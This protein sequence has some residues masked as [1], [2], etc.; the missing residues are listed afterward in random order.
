M[1]SIRPIETASF[2]ALDRT[3]SAEMAGDFAKAMESSGVFDYVLVPDQLVSWWPKGLWKSE[4][5]SMAEVSGDPDSFN[6]AFM[7]AA[8]AA[9]STKD[10][11]V[12]VSTDAIRRGPA[13]LMQA[14]LTL[15]GATKG[16]TACLIGA[17]EIKQ[18]RPW[19][20]KRSEGLK[21]MEDLFRIFSQLFECEEP[22]DFQGNVW[23]LR[24]AWVGSVR[25]YR[26]KFW[27]MG[28]GPKLMDI[29]A[30]H[31]DGFISAIPLVSSSPEQ[32]AEKVAHIKQLLEQEGRDPEE[33][34][35]GAFFLTAMHED[36]EVVERALDNKMLRWFAAALGRF[37]QTDWEREG[38][39]PVYPPD[40]H[41][42][43]KLLPDEIT[44]AELA[45]VDAKVQRKMVE[46]SLFIGTPAEV[47]KDLGAY[48]EAGAN[49][50]IIAD[51]LPFTLSQ[52]EMRLAAGH[53]IEVARILKGR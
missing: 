47:A 49:H 25:P 45:D 26:P 38:I 40:W 51:M 44:D 10:L 32:W 24:N 7:L 41:Y 50:F 14:M 34:T 12:M 1:S 9:A 37:T 15:A 6:D 36:R 8:I 29:A 27:A 33:F 39:E 42:A 18:C 16:K 30:K 22:I 5:T 21:R 17:G 19:G 13:E 52:E 11:G 3:W 23:N 48:A 4:N 46:K 28:G 20:Y 2:F 43:W 53:S 35:F 31:G